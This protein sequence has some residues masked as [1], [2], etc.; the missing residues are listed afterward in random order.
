MSK[1]IW[2]GVLT[3]AFIFFAIM[4]LW[5]L[6]HIAF[7]GL[8]F[9]RSQLEPPAAPTWAEPGAAGRHVS[10][11]PLGRKDTGI[12]AL[13]LDNTG[14]Y[15]PLIMQSDGAVRSAGVT[16][17]GSHWIAIRVDPQGRVICSPKGFTP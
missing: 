13:G 10:D 2:Q 9:V 6:T 1:L 14:D 15:A 5:D 7:R 12:M 3:F 16:S 11:I 17:D 8:E 4:G